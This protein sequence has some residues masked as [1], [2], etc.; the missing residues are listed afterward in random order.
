M[1]KNQA[2]FAH[3]V[4]EIFNHVGPDVATENTGKM[5]EI[6]AMSASNCCTH[7]AHSVV[8]DR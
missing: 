4:A 1:L 6:P 8:H 3:E 5:L 2:S 7:S